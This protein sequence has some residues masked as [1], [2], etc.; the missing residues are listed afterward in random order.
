M[1]TTARSNDA[2]VYVVDESKGSENAVMRKLCGLGP[3]EVTNEMV[4]RYLKYNSH[5]RSYGEMSSAHYSTTASGISLHPK[6]Y[7]RVRR[8]M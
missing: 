3:D 1:H 2:G 7:P 8:S 6:Y 4:A 5:K